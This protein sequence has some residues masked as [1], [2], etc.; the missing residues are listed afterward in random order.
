MNN[1]RSLSIKRNL[2]YI[3]LFCFFQI[4]V[5]EAKDFG[6]QGELF[7][8]LEEN[9]VSVLQQRLHSDAKNPRILQD[10]IKKKI[11][12]PKL[13]SIP[14][15]A[16]ENRTFYYDP[17]YT[18]KETIRDSKGKI[19]IHK[20]TNTNPLQEISLTHGLLFLDGKNP[21]HIKWALQ[22]LGSFHWILVDGNPFKLEEEQHRPVFFDQQSYLI[23]KFNI[24]HVP[25]RVSQEG[26][27][28]K[29]EE[30]HLPEEETLP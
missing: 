15:E 26:H 18:S 4:S 24:Q 1:N 17:T 19:L 27:R 9:L 16:S 5:C 7:P 23:S 14:Q 8:I 22:Q 29:I 25:A 2:T 10:Q 20:G 3:L 11:S 13:A 6:I 28:L 21:K 30:I 12:L